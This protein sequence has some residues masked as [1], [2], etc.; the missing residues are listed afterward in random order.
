MFISGAS[1]AQ[2]QT[3]RIFTPRQ[4]LSVPGDG[5]TVKF[6]GVNLIAG[7]KYR[8][9]A[10]GFISV[11]SSNDIADAAYY[12]KVISFPPVGGLINVPVTMKVRTSLSNEDWFYN[13]YQSSG[14]QNGSAQ[15]NHIYDATVPSSG[16]P[17]E[18]R[19][20][21][22]QYG[23]N[24]GSIQ[25][26]VSRE[27]PGIAIEKDTL[28]FG[29]VRVGSSARLTDS[30]GSYG[31]EGFRVD[32]VTLTGPSAAR[33]TVQSERIVP[34]GILETTNG[35]VFTYSP[36]LSGRD[37]AQF[38]IFSSNAFGSEKEK[39][40]YLYGNGISTKL[41][42]TSDT[43]DF[44]TIRTGRS[45]VLPD[46]IISSDNVIDIRNIIALT[47]GSM[48]SV[49]PAG[50]TQIT[51][52]LPISVTFSPA[53]D[54]KHFERF[55]VN[56][57]DGS[58]FSF[59]AKG[60]SG[61][62]DIRLEKDVLDFGKVILKQSRL[63]SDYFE[64]RGTGPI[65]IVST[66]NTNPTDYTVTAGNQGPNPDFESGHGITYSFTFSP[67]VH[68][69]FCVN[70]DGEFTW[71][72]DDG[73]S[74][75]VVFKGCD[76]MPLDA[77]L[78]IDTQYYVSAG[79]EIDVS[80]RL[81]TPGEPLDSTLV[82]VNSLTEKISYDASLFD[83]VSV[84]KGAAISSN[85]WNLGQTKSAGAVDI[86][87]SSATDHF[88]SSGSLLILRFKAHTD[89]KVGQFTNLIQNNIDFGNPLEP[90]AFSEAGKITISDLCSPV[91]ITVGS[92][93]TS[94]EQNNPN[95]FNPSTH[96]RFTVAKN[97]DGSA[98]DVRITLYDQLGR[99]SGVLVDE[100]KAP[101]IYDLLFD[102][103]RYSSGAYTYVFQVGNHVERKTML[104][105]K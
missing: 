69:P 88:H 19:F 14:F 99:F 86:S 38:H 37:S 94:I 55:D 13:Y 68:I 85:A 100:Q 60:V 83:L 77:I 49:T 105:I 39:I 22:T 80:Q 84:T 89:A 21:D 102:G 36:I 81:I 73:T 74:K 20:Q 75:T 50:R 78:M 97:A 46:T 62:P 91:H 52:A 12:W 70:H 2:A 101:G 4:T 27:T 17:L 15:S 61:T 42:F 5:S 40:I 30:I 18:F 16:V 96:I 54:G 64:N 92:F 72:F 45:K 87:I 11:S 53:T 51:G 33:F 7:M 48:F 35:F 23:D 43:I 41:S 9:H 59:Y 29:T 57:N 66:V 25:V 10:S 95:P 79:K 34:F 56:T 103:S 67:Q 24:V 32:N 47:S 82:P 65:S 63:L 71:F 31:A 98:A 8:V 6:P 44:G 90:F 1:I 76:H 26:E 58:V 28:D 3:W 93:A 104:L